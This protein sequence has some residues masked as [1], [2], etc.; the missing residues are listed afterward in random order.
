V[1]E[2]AIVGAREAIA[3]LPI[4]VSVIALGEENLALR[5]LVARQRAR[6]EP[7]FYHFV[8]DVQLRSIASG[9]LDTGLPVHLPAELAGGPKRSPQALARELEAEIGPLVDELA[10]IERA[11]E[12]A[13][14][15]GLDAEKAAR[16]EAGL[17]AS[18]EIG[19]PDGERARLEALA[20][21][22]MALELRFA[23]WFP[24]AAGVSGDLP[25]LG[26]KSGTPEGEDVEAVMCALASIA[27]VV[28]LL[29]GSELARR[30]DA[31]ELLERPHA[32]PLPRHS[33]RLAGVGGAFARGDTCRGAA[34]GVRRE[35][36]AG[37]LR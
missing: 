6:G 30:A 32:G 11:R 15:E 9:E 10:A 24:P 18:K 4:G 8:D 2:A 19:P 37:W 29:G 23:R 22:R 1:D 33:P 7:A 28:A 36:H 5:A 31:I 21:D 20:R 34:R 3:G 26:P 12:V 13:V 17:D 27:E 35:G 16:C 25:M 14:L